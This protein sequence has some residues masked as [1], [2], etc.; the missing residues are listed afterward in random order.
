MKTML[1]Q[2]ITLKLPGGKWIT[3]LAFALLLLVSMGFGAAAGLIFVYQSDL[4]EVRALEDYRPNVVTEVYSDDGQVIGSFALQRR[5]LL[6]YEQIPEILKDAVIVA[7]DQHFYEHWGID[8]PRVVQAAWRNLRRMRKA[9]GASTL[10]MQLGGTLFLDRTDR[11]FRRKIQEALLA[12][13]I[14]R[15]YSKEQIFTLYAN[16]VYLAHGNYGFEAAAQYYFG[17]SV[18][19]LTVPEAALLAG[20]LPGPRYSPLLNPQAALQRRNYVLRR[21]AEEGKISQAKAEEYI[22]LPLNLNV[23]SPKND[24]APYFVEEIRKYLERTYGTEEIG[25]AHV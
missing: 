23:Q 10:T 16:Q 11:S 13:Q 15:H 24:L 1:L 21:L 20:I 22:R 14:E 2:A 18:G 19:Q 7:E 4:P 9:E 5:V 6:T 3:R 25:R 8:L 12:M 17:K